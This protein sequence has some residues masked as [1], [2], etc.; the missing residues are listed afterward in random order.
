MFSSLRFRLWLTYLMV[1]GVVITIAGL[2]LAVYLLRNPAA[3]RREIQRLQLVSS[4]ALQ[5]G[6]VFN[7]QPGS[8][9]VA[10]MEEAVRRLDNFAGAR[11]A[12]FDRAGSLLV[13]SRAGNAPALPAWGVF[14]DKKPN[15]IPTFQDAA[16]RQ[17]LYVVTPME[18]GNV[19][20]VATPRPRFRAATLLREEF[21]TPFV[22][23]FLLAA[24][25]SL[26]LAFLIARWITAPLQHLAGAARSVS[27]GEFRK[28]RPQGPDEV[29]AVMQ[30][31]DEMIEQVQASQRSQRDFVANVSHD[32][33]TP[34][35]SVQG[36]AQAILDGTA[37]DAPSIQQ[38]AQVIYDESG[39]MYRMVLDLLDLA[40]LDAGTLTFERA[41]VDLQNLLAGIVNKFT[42][43]ARQAQVGLSF[44]T[45]QSSGALPTIIGDGDRLAQVFTNLVDNALKFTPAGGQVAILARAVDGSVEVGVADSGPGI[46][47]DELPRIFER[48]YQTD[49]ARRGGSRRGAGLGLAIAREIV[50]VHGGSIQAYNRGQAVAAGANPDQTVMA[51]K[52]SV[53][54]VRLPVVRP[55][56]E[57]LARRRKD[58]RIS[59]S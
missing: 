18:G 59:A 35:T 13:D 1:V 10:R 29:K 3:D 57:T 42:P 5:R 21:L 40:R 11:V 52:G 49:K 19:L 20:L 53:F 4:L 31:F 6:P 46:P 54:V 44:S 30:A 41:A 2:A 24:G 14:A 26:L 17:W 9:P 7:F 37:G 45:G 28:I 55:D 34:L 47:E 23:S 32:L 36:F 33:K 50:Q 58:A 51:G 16:G 27:A 39:R 15:I 8:M 48:F 22:R 12:M 38:A 56:D 25:L 43:Q